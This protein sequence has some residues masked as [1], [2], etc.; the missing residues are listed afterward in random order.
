MRR[1][2]LVPGRMWRQ[3]IH[4]RQRAFVEPDNAHGHMPA[5]KFLLLVAV[6]ALLSL[7]S[8]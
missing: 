2:R 3:I 8:R 6:V 4:R 1:A 7:A 5:G